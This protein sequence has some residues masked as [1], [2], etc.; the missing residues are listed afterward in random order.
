MEKLIKQKLIERGFKE[1]TLLNNIGL[2]GACIEE[3]EQQLRLYGVSV[4]LP[5][6]PMVLAEYL[7]D[8]YEQIAKRTKWQTQKSCKVEFKDLPIENKNT[9]ILLAGKLILDFVGNER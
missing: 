6:D 9:M 3:T 7:H 8:N 4:S 2:I 1:E 5:S